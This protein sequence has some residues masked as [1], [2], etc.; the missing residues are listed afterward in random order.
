MNTN[1]GMKYS[2]PVDST[3]IIRVI[4]I[5]GGGVNAVNYMYKS[6]IQ[7][8][9]FAVCNT[10]KQ[11][12]NGVDV[13]IKITLGSGMG[14]GGKPEKGREEFEKSAA[15]VEKLLDDGSSMV[16]ITTGMGGGTG[17]GAGPLLA[18]M[19]KAKGLLT[20]GI[21]TI[22]FLFEKVP[23]IIQALDAVEEM[24]KNVDALIVI[25]NEK[26]KV[27]YPDF[28]VDEAFKKPDEV[29]AMAVKSIAEIITVKGVINRDFNDVTSTMKDSGVALVSYGFGRGENRLDDA[30]QDALNSPLL[31][32]NDIYNAKRLLFYISSRKD[33]HFKVDELNKDIDNFMSRFDDHIEMIWGYGR[34]DSLEPEQEV[35]FTI[36]ATGFGL[37]AIPDIKEMMNENDLK[38]VQ[39]DIEKKKKNVKRVEAIYGKNLEANIKVKRVSQSSIVVLTTEEMDDDSFISFLESH[40]TYNRNPKDIAAK[41]KPAKETGKPELQTPVDNN[42]VAGDAITIEF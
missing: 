32:N 17:S 23:R 11:S 1:V 8:V 41:R 35:K 18:K 2:F 6:G 21:V 24:S 22:P 10:D 5:G 25:N 38:K 12:F 34:D 28:D 16:F 7:G 39:D 19:A 15:E 42:K 29:L 40:P 9:N 36:I 20:V 27:Y 37:D 26:L 31:S 3:K 33:A 4:G 13:P 30:I 14:S